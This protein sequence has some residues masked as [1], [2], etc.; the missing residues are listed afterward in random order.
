MAK[1]QVDP[2]S[3]G[4]LVNANAKN[5]LLVLPVQH[6]GWHGQERRLLHGDAAGRRA[7]ARHLHVHHDHV[8][9]AARRARHRR[10]RRR[11]RP[12]LA[13][14]PRRRLR[15][16]R[17]AHQ[18]HRAGRADRGH[19]EEEHALVLLP[20]EQAPPPLRRRHA[21]TQGLAVLDLVHVAG[22]RRGEVFQESRR[23]RSRAP[24]MSTAR[25]GTRAGGR[26]RRSR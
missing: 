24:G 10:R 9:L 21:E 22:M 17:D 13:P 15:A 4:L 23:S 8:R 19:G 11:V 18:R 26:R 14:V 25:A 3:G 6:L 12:H 7:A 2:D 16:R 20:D 1:C 5:D